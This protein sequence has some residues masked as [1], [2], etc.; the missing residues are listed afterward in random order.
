MMKSF[1]SSSLLVIILGCFLVGDHGI[2]A[3]TTQKLRP[4]QDANIFEGLDDAAAGRGR[5]TV[6]YRNYTDKGI[7][8]SRALVQFD[9]SSLPSDAQIVSAEILMDTYGRTRAGEPDMQAHRVTAFW[10]TEASSASGG[11]SIPANA[12]TGDVTWK[13]SSYNSLTW[14]NPGGDFEPEVL[15]LETNKER[16]DHIF[17]ST[18]A[19]VDVVQGWVDGTY[20]NYGFMLLD[21]EK[22]PTEEHFRLFFGV[23]TGGRGGELLVSYTSESEPVAP[24]TLGPETSPPGNS[25]GGGG[26]TTGPPNPGCEGNDSLGGTVKTFIATKDAMILDGR[27][28]EAAANDILVLGKTRDGIRRIAYQFDF[29]GLPTDA[30]V[31]CAEFDMMVIGDATTLGTN[32][33]IKI[34]RLEEEW[35]ADTTSSA[36]GNNGSPAQPGDVTWTYRKYPSETWM[37]PGGTFDPT[38][39]SEK[40]I[41][42]AEDEIILEST[43]AMTSTMQGILDGNLPNYGF[44]L[45]GQEDADDVS[46][47]VVW[48]QDKARN[49]RNPYVAIRYRSTTET[50]TSFSMCFSS[51]STVEVQ[52]VGTITMDKLK[53]GDHV[54]TDAGRFEPVYSFGHYDNGP[55][56][57]SVFFQI[58]ASGLTTPLELSHDH[59]VFILIGDNDQRRTRKTVTANKVQIGDTLILI[60]DS[61][62]NNGEQQQHSVAVVTKISTVS[63]HGAFAPFTPSGMIVVNNVLASNYVSLLNDEND[64][65]WW[66]QSVAHAS[67][68]FRRVYCGRGCYGETYNDDDGIANWVR[69][70]LAIGQ[71]LVKNTMSL[72]TA[73]AA[74]LASYYVAVNSVKKSA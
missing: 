74:L 27:P 7:I 69:I 25:G 57:K 46:Q 12:T 37:N 47:V 4:S 5:F 36:D 23:E 51:R 72:L 18:Q 19:L 24:P 54:K 45:I 49:G 38:V 17:P 58:H 30:Q 63:R 15:S 26:P 55:T 2:L 20:P 9:L 56:Q 16:E 66:M 53:I 28:D 62:K 65:P 29:A 73:T 43:T 35:T 40:L 13:Y 11:G 42:D 41:D 8:E 68:W 61:N 67:V 71:F 1:P 44:I 22:P 6:G 33:V 60:K 14:T 10:T 31:L 3:M 59:M 21:P 50:I 34:H 70:P 48:P 39:L 52:D 32:Q 64:T